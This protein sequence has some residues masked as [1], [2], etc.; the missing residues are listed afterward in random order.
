MKLINFGVLSIIALLTLN[1]CASTENI[2]SDA[3]ESASSIFPSWYQNAEFASDSLGYMGFATAVAADSAKA[4]E[5]AELQAR[6]NLE[7][8]IAQLTEEIRTDLDQA[9]STDA[10]NA[11]FIIIL[12]TA[13]SAVVDAANVTGSKATKMDGYYRGFASVKL[14]KAEIRTVL[15]NGF[16]GHPRYWGGFS[17]SDTFNDYFR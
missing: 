10:N 15:E 4:T 17:S 6:F 16:N 5:R 1:S 9:G 13:H 3:V 2:A 8:R 12:R 14:T 7:K 11:D